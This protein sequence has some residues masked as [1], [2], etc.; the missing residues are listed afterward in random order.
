MASMWRHM[1]DCLK[2]GAFFGALA[3]V[4][5]IFGEKI[6]DWLTKTIPENWIYLGNWSIPIY[7]IVI[8][9]ITGYIVDRK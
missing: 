7:L 2:N 5:I 6:I 9:A 4:G 1:G 3:A 8:L